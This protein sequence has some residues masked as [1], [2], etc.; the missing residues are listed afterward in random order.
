[1]GPGVDPHLYK[2]SAGDVQRLTSAQ[3]I[4]YNGLH[5]ES[6]MGDI[7]AKTVR[8]IRKLLLLTDAVD[9]NLL[10]TPPEFEGQ[11]RSALMV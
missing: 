7:L 9:R 10:L 4:F 1:M 6:K 8:E 5:L 2:A 3:L 11:S